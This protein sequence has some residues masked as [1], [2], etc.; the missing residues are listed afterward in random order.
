M[1]V[2]V[3]LSHD[4]DL[5]ALARWDSM[6]L[7]AGWRLVGKSQ[8]A[9]EYYLDAAPD[10]VSRVAHEFR[11]WQ[12]AIDSIAVEKKGNGRQMSE[13]GFQHEE[14]PRGDFHAKWEAVWS[15]GT[16]GAVVTIRKSDHRYPRYCVLVQGVRPDGASSPWF[17][18]R[19]YAGLD[20]VE[21]SSTPR[22]VARLLQ[23]ANEWI[24]NDVQQ[25][26][27]RMRA[28]Q[29]DRARQAEQRPAPAPAP[30]APRAPM[31]VGKTARDRRRKLERRKQQD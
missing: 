25:T 17:L 24:E 22:E 10:I 11:I 30:R 12:V 6:R 31:R 29:E 27:D 8:Y 19:A 16:E 15:Y 13:M 18:V 28:Q 21:V 7:P 2:T 14:A 3:K 5:V 23:D 9:R 4:V 1:R 20:K 26:A